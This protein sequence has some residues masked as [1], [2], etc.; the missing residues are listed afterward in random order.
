VAHI[1]QAVKLHAPEAD[2]AHALVADLLSTLQASPSEQPQLQER[3]AMAAAASALA[4]FAGHSSS[5]R[6]RLVAAGAVPPLV[7]LLTLPLMTAG[8]GQPHQAA[9]DALFALAGGLAA[10]R[11]GALSDADMITQESIAAAG[12]I[13]ALTQLLAGAWR[14]G[15][16]AD[17]DAGAGAE[18][19]T[20]G[21]PA[22]GSWGHG[23]CLGTLSYGCGAGGVN[24]DDDDEYGCP[25]KRPGSRG[26]GRK[27]RAPPPPKVRPTSGTK[28]ERAVAAAWQMAA[29]QALAALAACPRVKAIMASEGCAAV[30]RLIRLLGSNRDGVV[31]AALAA[32]QQLM[33]AGDTAVDQAI[34]ACGGVAMLVQAA[35]RSSEL[36]AC[37]ALQLLHQLSANL[38]AAPAAAAAA[39]PAAGAAASDSC[40]GHSHDSFVQQ[41]FVQGFV[42]VVLGQL[43]VLHEPRAL[44]HGASLL[45]QVLT[46]TTGQM[47]KVALSGAAAAAAPRNARTAT[48]QQLHHQ[49]LACAAPAQPHTRTPTNQPTDRPL[50][51]PT[52]MSSASLTTSA[53]ARARCRRAWACSRSCGPTPMRSCW[54]SSTASCASSRRQGSSAVHSHAS[55]CERKE[56]RHGL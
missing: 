15:G 36:H 46:R 26:G 7:K 35:G 16:S 25:K 2:V 48:R 40:S 32:L 1:S 17:T 29:A 38:S 37:T 31:T 28:E 30:A 11:P 4:G 50:Q 12:S 41:L 42:P 55:C 27:Q 47:R 44:K 34:C 3:A 52:T 51:A 23:G 33:R 21:T 8:G 24:D 49:H 45:L 14:R 56:G 5:N 6:H 22:D 10:L 9:A 43:A 54:R 53:S 13:E 20:P 39:A 19:V 18:P